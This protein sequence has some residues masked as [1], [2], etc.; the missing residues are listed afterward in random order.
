MEHAVIEAIMKND[1]ADASTVEFVDIGAA[2]F[3]SVIG[4][5][6]DFTWIFY[7][8]DGVRAELENIPLNIIMLKDFSEALD[9]Y[10]PT[11]I[12]SEK[13]I[14]NK[15][16][17]V[18]KFMAATSKGYEFAITNPAEA[19]EI[20]L[21]YAPELNAELVSESQKW[22]S[23][24]YQA[25]A[26]QWGWQSRDVWERYASWMYEQELLPKAIDVDKAYTNEFLPKG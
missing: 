16:D 1:G 3:F 22:L 25:D 26:P 15:P 13:T 5:Q 4:K 11:I 20:L 7:G 6:V 19:A 9:Y 18:K 12:T 21:K 14:Q 8:W 17:L 2:D 24:Q 23:G 10:T